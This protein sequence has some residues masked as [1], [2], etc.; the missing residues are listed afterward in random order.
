M[1]K[2]GVMSGNMSAINYASLEDSIC[3]INGDDTEY[4]LISSELDEIERIDM[5]NINRESADITAGIDLSTTIHCPKTECTG[6]V[7]DAM[8]WT[9]DHF[10]GTSLPVSAT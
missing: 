2:P 7:V 6:V 8:N 3:A 10:F 1:T 9:F 5:I 4:R